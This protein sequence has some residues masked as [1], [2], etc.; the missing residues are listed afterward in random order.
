MG[1][2]RNVA[3]SLIMAA[4]TLVVSAG[5][6]VMMWIVLDISWNAIFIPIL[7]VAGLSVYVYVLS[8]RGE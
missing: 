6:I 5:L 1:Q 7:I 3:R 2:P 8:R 4:G